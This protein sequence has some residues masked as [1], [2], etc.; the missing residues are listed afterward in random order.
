M[1]ALSEDFFGAVDL[2]SRVGDGN[3]DDF[4]NGSRVLT[5]EIEQNDLAI[6]GT[7]LMDHSHQAFQH[8]SPIWVV[9]AG[10]QQNLVEADPVMSDR[11]PHV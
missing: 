10:Q 11:G 1:E 7:E 8:Q 4:R 2:S 6:E 5:F 3:P 9:R